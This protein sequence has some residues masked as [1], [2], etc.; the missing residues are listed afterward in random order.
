M[1][2][3]NELAAGGGY[4]TWEDFK[5]TSQIKVSSCL[6]INV[7]IFLLQDSNCKGCNPQEEVTTS[8]D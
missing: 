6:F 3:C 4:Q 1:C 8:H 2:E 5:P 7:K